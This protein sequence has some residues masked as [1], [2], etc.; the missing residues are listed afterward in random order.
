MSLFETQLPD[1][2]AWEP[3]ERHYRI[4]KKPRALDYSVLETIPFVPMEAVPAK[5]QMRVRYELRAR[6]SITSGTY[7]ERGDV[8]LSKI[9]PSFENG[10]QGKAEELPGAFGVASTEIIPIQPVAEASE[11]YLFYYLLHPE[12]RHHLAAKMEGSTGRQRVPEHA[13]RELMVPVPPP[14]EQVDIARTLRLVQRAIT[15]E[16]FLVVTTRELTHAL[17]QELFTRGLRGEEQKGT[18]IGS[19]PESWEVIPLG[20]VGKIGNGSTPKRT[21]PR[22]W[23]GG[24]F[25]WLTSGKIHERIISEADELVTETAVRECHLP[26]VP[27]GSLLI[28]ITGQGKTLGNVALTTIQTCVSQHL[29]Y[30]IV[31]HPEV[32]ANFMRHYL[33][34][35]YDYLRSLGQAGGSTKGALTCA[36]LKMVPVPLPRLPEQ[37]EIA[38]MLDLLEQ[39]VNH[40]ERKRIILTEL[41]ET[42]L[43][44][45]MTGRIRVADLDI[46]AKVPAA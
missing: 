4:T 24:T 23:Q 14:E 29:A 6:D 28:A 40:H 1:G 5:G 8:L 16:E 10:K 12:V 27:A 36:G 33:S 20:S 39:K 35:R 44:N 31:E 42:L 21:E 34:S 25:P 11:D 43:H 17:M 41:F 7:F 19:I 26:L 22:Y 3:L 9:T 15:V 37:R 13:V 46:K 45:L 38:H 18:E 2:W 32:D 30:V